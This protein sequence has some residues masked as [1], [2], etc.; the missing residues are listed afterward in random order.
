MAAF[1]S[2]HFFC[3]SRQDD[4]LKYLC[5][6]MNFISD[7]IDEFPCLVVADSSASLATLPLFLVRIHFFL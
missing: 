4:D 3:I 7:V 5:N 1:G 6:L 2:F